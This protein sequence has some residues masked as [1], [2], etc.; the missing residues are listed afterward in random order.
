M[1]YFLAASVLLNI[2]GLYEY[3]KKTR[4]SRALDLAILKCLPNSVSLAMFDYE[5]KDIFACTNGKVT[6]VNENGDIIK[7]GNVSINSK[8]L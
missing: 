6:I 4:E 3:H 2:F 1:K 8:S 5:G 7:E